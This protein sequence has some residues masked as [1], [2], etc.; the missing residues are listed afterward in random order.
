MK[1][2]A[3]IIVDNLVCFARSWELWTDDTAEEQYKVSRKHNYDIIILSQST[4][5]RAREKLCIHKLHQ[6]GSL[7]SIAA[8]R[9]KQKAQSN[10]Q[11]GR[12]A[13]SY[14]NFLITNSLVL[15]PLMDKAWDENALDVLRGL[16]LTTVWWEFKA[17]IFYLATRQPHCYC[18]H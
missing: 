1:L 12:L 3:I 15:F 5:A 6:P 2:V 9:Q 8:P 17:G 13:A 16:S 4:D 7:C 14:V 11:L 10:P 18:R